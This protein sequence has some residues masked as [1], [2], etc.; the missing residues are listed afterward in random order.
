MSISATSLAVP[1]GVVPI[2]RKNEEHYD[3]LND[4]DDPSL[5]MQEGAMI[6]DVKDVS[7][8]N[9]SKCAEIA[10]MTYSKAAN[11]SK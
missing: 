10:N 1:R 9:L 3:Y 5:L 2:P 7:N 6:E 4:K 11:H 8:L